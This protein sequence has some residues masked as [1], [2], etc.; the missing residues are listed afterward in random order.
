VTFIPHWNNKDGGDELDTS[1]CFMGISRFKQLLAMLPKNQTVIGID[2]HTALSI[3][4]SAVTCR[5]LGQGS[6]TL[7][8]EGQE[9][10]FKAGNTF[11]LSELGSCRAP[12]PSDG[13]PADIWQTALEIHSSKGSQSEQESVPPEVEILVEK[14]KA[15]RNENDWKTADDLRDRIEELGWEIRDSP[16]GPQ[17]NKM[18]P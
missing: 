2:E 12:E 11:N 18:D 7:I 17:L 8:R 16:S 14:R 15:A 3:D 6:V 4:C 10:R 13:I 5:V 1:R 9:D